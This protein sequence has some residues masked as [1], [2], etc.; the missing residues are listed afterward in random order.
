M[1]TQ[2][3]LA[4]HGR[5]NEAAGNALAW[6]TESGSLAAVLTSLLIAGPVAAQ[7]YSR[8]ETISYHDNTEI[9]VLGQV[10]ER[11]INGLAAERT[12]Y[13]ART[14]LPVQKWSFGKLQQTLAY[15]ADGTVSTVKDANSNVTTIPAWKRGIPQSIRYADGTSR[16]AAV[17]DN[18]W[19]TQTVDENGYATS[20]AYDRMGR[21]TR[22]EYPAGDDD[23]WNATI[24]NFVQV[25]V[26]E[27]GIPAGHW[28]QTTSTGD[29]IRI[30]YF[31]AMWRPLLIREYDAKNIAG[32]Q[33]FNGFEYDHAGRTVFASYPSVQ[34]NPESGIWTSYDALGRQIQV[35]QDSERGVLRTTTS[36]LSDKTGVYTLVTKPGGQQTR[37]MYQVFDQPSYDTPVKI[38]HPEGVVTTINRDIFGKPT[39][40]VRGSSDGAVKAVRSYAYNANQELCRSVE[41]ETGA[42]LMGYDVAGNL[43]W[44]AAGLSPDTACHPTGLEPTIKA[45][46]VVRTYDVRNR[47]KTLSFPDQ[48]GD[49]TWEYTA[50]GLPGSI[51]AANVGTN[52]VTTRYSYNRKRLLTEERVF[53]NKLDWPVAY[54]YNANGHLSSESYPNNKSVAYAPNALGQPTRAG[55]FATNVRYHPNGALKE[56]R[57]GNGIVHQMTQNA[58][59]LPLRSTDCLVSDCQ[60]ATDRRVDLT[61]NYDRNANI[62]RIAD[63]VS[64]RQSRSMTYDG[65]DR[66]LTTTSR[67]FGTAS[68]AYDALDNLTRVGVSAGATARD[69]FYCYNAKWQLTDVMKDSCAGSSVVRLGYDVQGNMINKN[70]SVFRFDFGNRLRAVKGNSSYIYDGLGRRIRDYTSASKYSQYSR[71]GRLMYTYDARLGIGTQYVYLGTRLI[72]LRE[73]AGKVATPKYQHSD[74]LG[75]PIAVTGANKELLETTEYEPYGLVV[76]R[77]EKDGPGFTGH[78]LDASTG[79]NYMQQRYYDPQIGRFLSVDPVTAYSK[80]TQ[81]F[82]RYR[83]ANSSP[84]RFHDP[85][86][87]DGVLREAERHS[88]TAHVAPIS[89]VPQLVLPTVN[90]LITSGYGE[91]IHPVTGQRKMHNGTDFRARKGDAIK[92]TQS[93]VVKAVTSGG[94]GGSQIVIM[95]SDGSMSGYAHTAPA[96][97]VAVGESVTAG[98]TIGNSDGSGR[99]TAPHLHYT[100]RP[101]TKEAPATEATTPVDAEQTQFSRVKVPRK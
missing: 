27:Y 86:G 64:A 89:P 13:D 28:R 46:R 9:W 63:G 43:A 45:R 81:A 4:R 42:T 37:T 14:A 22:T 44:S 23:S 94:S 56:F 79:M 49:Q 40:I 34:D 73:A 97:G 48:F 85:D 95:N 41:P 77:P 88:Q 93:G 52:T 30:T 75:S 72:A 21:L 7:G 91:R 61:Y 98:S 53:W 2:Q 55:T 80:P 74:S 65:L 6:R 50:D 33:R 36:Y 83:Y 39:S 3:P 24:Q 32:T 31:D 96:D 19:I 99:I 29:G 17:D 92:S 66:L 60:V 16:S 84:Y 71:D 8:T 26:P 1:K 70:G 10:A 12:K 62:D 78:V 87:R 68:Y 15:H 58:R 35:S 59:Q 100:Y 38:Y 25:D 47:L 67:A 51:V 101:G 20:Y 11:S 90:G 54:T 76:N 69:H 57:Y 18:G 82:N 5:T